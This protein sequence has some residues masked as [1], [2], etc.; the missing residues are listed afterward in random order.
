MGKGKQKQKKKKQ[1]E[2]ASDANSAA[3]TSSG[4][5]ATRAVAIGLFTLGIGVVA[6]AIIGSP[7]RPTIQTTV[8]T[9]AN[10]TSDGKPAPYFDSVEEAKPFP[11]TLPPSQFEND[12]LKVSYSIAKDIPEVLVQQPCLCGC[13]LAREGHGSLLD[14]FI[15]D[16]AS[17]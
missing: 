11:V 13:N 6:Y 15:D 8:Q 1:A 9:A 12:I 5:G 10:T 2:P 7:E 16:H 4:G 3:E 17:T 14:C